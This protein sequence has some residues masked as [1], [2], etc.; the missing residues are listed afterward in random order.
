M[1]RNVLIRVDNIISMYK[2]HVRQ[3]N[4]I[5]IRCTILCMYISESNHYSANSF[6][7]LLSTVP[8]VCA[9]YFH[10]RNDYIDLLPLYEV[11]VDGLKL[12]AYT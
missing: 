5:D 10:T 11:F 9:Y 8:Q 6:I 7:L 4:I 1:Y 2:L 3:F 12:S